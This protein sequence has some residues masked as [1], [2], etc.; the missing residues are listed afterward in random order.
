MHMMRPHPI[1][2]P[3]FPLFPLQPSI[4]KSHTVSQQGR[5]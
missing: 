5:P 4:S 3:F 1:F 2:P